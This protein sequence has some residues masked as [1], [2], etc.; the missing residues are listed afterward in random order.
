MVPCPATRITGGLE[1]QT[2]PQPLLG[3][4]FQQETNGPKGGCKWCL[5][6]EPALQGGDE[7]SLRDSPQHTCVEP[8]GVCN[9]LH[10]A[11]AAQS[12]SQCGIPQGA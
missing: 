8:A 12:K 10:K 3:V 2:K 9:L 7:P 4:D 6:G 1:T 5:A 11:E